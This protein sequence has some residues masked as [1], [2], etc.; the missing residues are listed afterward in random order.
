MNYKEFKQYVDKSNKNIADKLKDNEEELTFYTMLVKRF[1]DICDENEEL[2]KQLE[3][4]YCN[5][6][7][8]S[9]RI[10]DSKQYDSLVQKVENQ[11]Q[12]FINYLEEEKDR[13]AKE[14]SAVYENDLGETKL[15]NE[16]IFNEIVKIELKYKEIMR[17]KNE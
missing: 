5:R 10:K 13:L 1:N 11:Q 2:K 17:L 15:V 14:I 7:D 3:H 16:D 4:C 8:C 6:T 9:S 12:K